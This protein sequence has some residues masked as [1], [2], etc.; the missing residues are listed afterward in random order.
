MWHLIA[1][2]YIIH[3]T[4]I[5]TCIYMNNY[6]VASI[7]HIV[8]VAEDCSSTIHNITSTD[9][10]S[11]PPNNSCPPGFPH[12][13]QG[14]AFFLQNLF[15]FLRLATL[16]ISIICTC[17]CTWMHCTCMSWY[18]LMVVSMFLL[19]TGIAHIGCCLYPHSP[20]TLTFSEDNVYSLFVCVTFVHVTSS[21]IV[22]FS[23]LV[24]KF[25]RTEEEVW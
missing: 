21:C 12:W 11:Q 23:T 3:V 2:L 24:F 1:G 20:P 25:G 4:Y 13:W 14:I 18:I 15:I 16:L 22:F 9:S 10:M 6:Y 19:V 7:I 5:Y 17:T 8:A